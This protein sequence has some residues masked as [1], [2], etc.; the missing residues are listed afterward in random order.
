MHV[1]AGAPVS[2]FVVRLRC[3]QQAFQPAHCCS[4]F[5]QRRW[6]SKYSL[7]HAA[8]LARM[9]STVPAKRQ[10]T[11]LTAQTDLPAVENSPEQEASVSDPSPHA[12]APPQPV[13]TRQGIV[14]GACSGYNTAASPECQTS[15]CRKTKNLPTPVLVQPGKLTSTTD[16]WDCAA[17]LVDKPQTWTSFDV[18]NKLKGVL[19][20]KKV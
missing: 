20:V 8:T 19:K 11:A 4:S 15:C 1:S 2:R 7:H 3:W 14:A 6:R 17:L 13:Q 16:L 12:E 9:A 5:A 18:C 10:R